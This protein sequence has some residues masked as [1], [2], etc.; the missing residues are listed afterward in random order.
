[1]YSFG[2]LLMHDKQLFTVGDVARRLNVSPQRVDYVIRTYNIRETQRAGILRLYD[3]STMERIE[4]AVRQ[5][6]GRHPHE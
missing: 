6:S 1:M 3:Q 5:T 4:R 2:D